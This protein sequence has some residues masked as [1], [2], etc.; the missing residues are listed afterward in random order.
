MPPST[1]RRIG[2][3]LASLP[4]R[5]PKNV[6]GQAILRL[7][8]RWDGPVVETQDFASLPRRIPK[9]AS[10]QEILRLI[11]VMSLLQGLSNHLVVNH[12][13]IERTIAARHRFSIVGKQFEKPG[14][15]A[16]CF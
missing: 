13:K 10:L 6:S 5:I 14:V 2:I 1:Q 12:R 8:D 11:R 9:K 15:I 3:D 4:R 7:R 16:K